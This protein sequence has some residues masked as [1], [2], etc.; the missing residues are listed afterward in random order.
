MWHFKPIAWFVD[1]E[2]SV[3]TRCDLLVGFCSRKRKEVFT[4]YVVNNE[5]QTRVTPFSFVLSCKKEPKKPIKCENVK[6]LL[7]LVWAIQNRKLVGWRRA[8]VRTSYNLKNRWK[9]AKHFNRLFTNK[10]G[11]HKETTKD[12]S[13][14]SLPEIIEIMQLLLE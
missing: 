8:T 4:A 3:R 12:S 13:E 11:D 14:R 9:R 2:C 10:R 1:T 6:K 7:Q 5:F